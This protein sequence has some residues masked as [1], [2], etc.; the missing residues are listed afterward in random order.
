[1]KQVVKVNKY[2]NVRVKTD[3]INF[4]SKKEERRYQDLKLLHRAG[5]VTYFIVHPV[6]LLQ[7]SFKDKWTG[8]YERA[9]TYEGDFAVKYTNLDHWVVEDI[10]GGNATKTRDFMNKRKMFLKR[11]PCLELRLL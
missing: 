10:K 8:K 2:H 5:E 7:E 11:Y 1:M 4:D 6:F 9:I 3:G